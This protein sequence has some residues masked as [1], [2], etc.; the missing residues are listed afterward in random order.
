MH[1]AL[2][3]RRPPIPCTHACVKEWWKKYR[4]A[5]AS[6]GI[7]TAK[8][9]EDKYGKAVRHLASQYPTSYK[10]SKALREMDSPLY[11]SDGIAKEW[12]RKFGGQSDLR[13]ID[14]AGHLEM[15]CGERIRDHEA[16]AAD[17]L[18]SW[19]LRE[20]KVSV[21][22]RVCQTWL[23]RD[24]S[25]SGRLL[26][27]DSVEEAAGERLRLREYGHC[28]ADDD[29]AQQLSHVLGESQPS[30]HVS[31]LVLRQWH[32]K[33]H[34]DSR[35]LEYATVR[36]L[37]EAIGEELRAVYDGLDCRALRSALGMRRKAV[38][39]SKQVC[40]TWCNS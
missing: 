40:D 31:V 17:E 10:F 11:V 29:S 38:L 34:P 4:A 9:F 15:E 5:G 14:S 23:T 12:L 1:K 20:H 35:P 18:A 3:E 39:V 8:E 32:T 36:A 19:L 24:W 7:K 16:L 27:A 30:L 21:P 2:R 6:E 13:N 33:F 26:T 25:S 37:E 28:F 22:S